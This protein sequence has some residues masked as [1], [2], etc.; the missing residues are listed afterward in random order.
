M[1]LAQGG[2]FNPTTGEFR[3]YTKATDSELREARAI[4][5]ET[6]AEPQPMSDL[7]KLGRVFYWLGLVELERVYKLM[8]AEMWET[9]RR[10][11]G[12]PPLPVGPQGY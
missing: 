9:W 3:A 6:K 1:T 2:Y 12:R 7:E 5:W 8:D 11:P 10:D 4:V